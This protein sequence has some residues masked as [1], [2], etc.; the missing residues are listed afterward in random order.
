ME[1]GLAWVLHH[2][3]PYSGAKTVSNRQQQTSQPDHGDRNMNKLI[4]SDLPKSEELDRAAIA[5]IFGGRR[6]I[7]GFG[8]IQPDTSAQPLGVSPGLPPS[9]YNTNIYKPHQQL[10]LYRDPAE[11]DKLQC[12][13]RRWQYWHHYQ[14][15]Q[16][17][18]ALMQP[19]RP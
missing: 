18:V 1:P 12:P 3:W 4:I 6:Y 11:P 10:R 15:L 13:Q 8:F 19:V 16:H 2:V 7:S 9:I 5:V 14:Q 17:L